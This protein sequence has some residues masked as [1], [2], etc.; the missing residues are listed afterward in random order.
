MPCASDLHLDEGADYT[1]GTWRVRDTLEQIDIVKLL[2]QKYRE[3]FELVTTSH[4][5][6][7]AF[8]N[9]KVAS[10]IGLEGYA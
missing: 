3:T 8:D 7:G 9:G 4:G 5:I 6:R 2:V 1:K 10:L